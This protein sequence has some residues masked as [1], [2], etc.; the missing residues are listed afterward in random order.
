MNRVIHFEIPS[1]DVERSQ[2]FF[3]NVFGWKYDKWGDMPYWMA[4]TGEDDKP[5]IH[6]ALMPKD[7]IAQNVVNTIGIEDAAKCRAAIEANGGQVLG[8]TQTVPTIGYFFYFK[9][10][11][12]N[13]HGAMQEDPTAQ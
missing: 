2:Q 8:E 12:G 10:P 5:G 9:D 11:D 4:S 7:E 3:S 6:G 1:N 13:L